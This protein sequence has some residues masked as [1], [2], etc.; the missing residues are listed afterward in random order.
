M[1][2]IGLLFCSAHKGKVLFNIHC[3]NSAQAASILSRQPLTFLMRNSYIY[4]QLLHISPP[5]T[6]EITQTTFDTEEL[7]LIP[8]TLEQMYNFNDNPEKITASLGV[9]DSVLFNPEPL[10]NLNTNFILPRLQKAQA[11]DEVFCTRWLAV[12]KELNCIVA[13]FLIKKGPDAD[14]ELEIGYGVYPA[15]ER[16]GWMTKVVAGF[17]QW[18]QEQPRVKTVMAETAKKNISSIRVLQ[19]NGFTLSRETDKFFYWRKKVD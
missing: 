14:G 3:R 8:L 17:L 6:M 9:R 10:S 4:N 13:D 16:K 11:E 1:L 7:L 18:A 5:T 2:H 12:S 15:H 19:K